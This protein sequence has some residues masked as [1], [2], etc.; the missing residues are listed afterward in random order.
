[1]E[2]QEIEE[3]YPAMITQISRDS[4]EAIVQIDTLE[5]TKSFPRQ[6]LAFHNLVAI[7]D[8]FRYFPNE[9]QTLGVYN[10]RDFEPVERLSDGPTRLP[11]NL[12][13]DLVE[14]KKD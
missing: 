2:V 5:I 13:K 8:R 4:T 10:V 7:G 9:R 6:A 12:L 3:F 1:M 14:G 11:N